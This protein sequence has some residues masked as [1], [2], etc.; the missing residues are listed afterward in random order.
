[1]CGHRALLG[2]T[3][4]TK[5]EMEFSPVPRVLK[6]AFETA[7][8]PAAGALAHS[9]VPAPTSS[10]GAASAST[11]VAGAGTG[12]PLGELAQDV[13]D[14]LAAFLHPLDLARL[15]L[16]SRGLLRDAEASAALLL[17][18]QGALAALPHHPKE[19]AAAAAGASHRYRY[20]CTFEVAAAGGEKLKAAL[21][22]IYE[23]S[24][25]TAAEP[26]AAGLSSS[27]HGGAQIKC[28]RVYVY[29]GRCSVHLIDRLHRS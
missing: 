23:D 29:V 8:E 16:C 15:G 11:R 26:V 22:C 21:R 4:P 5:R 17:R 6:A 2:P 24:A 20:L 12:A 19:A 1:M 27:A 28:V 3:L 14:A 13:L 25:D 7:P 10:A 9:S 18:R